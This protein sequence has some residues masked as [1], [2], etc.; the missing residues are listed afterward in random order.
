MKRILLHGA[1]LCLGALLLFSCL[2]LAQADEPAEDT[3]VGMIRTHFSC[4]CEG[5]AVGTM[6]SRCG[7]I[8]PAGAL[9]CREHGRIYDTIG[10]SFGGGITYERDFT[11]RAFETFAKG[12]DPVNDIAYI[13]F[14][15]TLGDRTGWYECKTVS[16]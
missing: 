7:M 16:Y 15:V 4:G 8:A 1:A 9:Y 2:Q 12:Y 14:P 5:E 11:F 13:K 3:R 10:F 6:I